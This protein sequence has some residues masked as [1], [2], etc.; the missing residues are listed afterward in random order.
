MVEQ[1]RHAIAVGELVAHY[2]PK[3]D[4]RTRTVSGT[5]A[6]LRWQHPQRGLLYPDAF[7]ELAESSGLMGEMTVSVL[8]IAL[9]QTRRWRDAGHELGIAV[10]VSPSNLV[11]VDFPGAVRGVLRRHAI[12]PEA[13]TLEVTES[14]LMEDR[15]RAVAVLTDLRESGVRMS[16][17]DYGTGYSSL[18][19]LA[20]LP[21]CELKLDRAL[22]A[23]M[24][25]SERNRVIVTSTIDL[26]HALG[27]G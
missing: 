21:I 19:Y 5:E 16:V 9:A 26:A 20:E 2:Q 23:A 14:V 25:S 7:I 3:L 12:P 6:L 13:L 24:T 22:V 8:D 10:N 11:D 18:A 17:D 15:E 27:V 4:L 1:L